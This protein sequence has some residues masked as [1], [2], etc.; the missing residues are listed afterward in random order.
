M[1]N[2]MEIRLNGKK[3]CLTA[4]L[5]VGDLIREKGLDPGTIVVEH[6][7]AIIA[8]EDLDRVTLKDNDSLEILRFV[9]GG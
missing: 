9:G 4:T 1:E 8:T 3:A 5:T 6:N 7:L 2:G